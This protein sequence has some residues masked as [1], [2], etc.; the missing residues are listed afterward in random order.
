V[1]YLNTYPLVWGMLHGPQKNV[2]D[3]SFA[4]PSVCADRLQSGEADIGIVPCAELERL[5]LDYLTDVGIACRGAVRSILL[6]SKGPVQKVRTLAADISSRSSVMLARIVVAE[7]YGATPQVISMAPNLPAMMS[8][9]DAALII[10]D[11]ALA[12]DPD[13]LPYTVLDLGEEWVQMTGLPMVFAVWA[14]RT[15][16]IDDEV[17]RVFI[18]SCRFGL[19]RLD[20]VVEDAVRK[21]SMSRE[22]ARRY[23]TE[24]LVLELGPAERQGLELF[25][26]K[27]SELHERDRVSGGILVP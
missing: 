7:R 11:P 4:V 3:I 22:F 15:A 12:L 21:Y 13:T 27:V 9:A 25:R 26:R 18:D 5:Q 14:G 6:I 10:G 1:S 23:L 19:A 17:G 20:D 24:N 16:C 2:F 8:A